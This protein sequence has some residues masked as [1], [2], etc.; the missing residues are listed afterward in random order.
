MGLDDETSESVPPL[1]PTEYALVMA[2][3]AANRLGFA[4]LPALGARQ[5]L[6]SL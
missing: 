1:T 5:P 6:W 4:L 2:K 3:N